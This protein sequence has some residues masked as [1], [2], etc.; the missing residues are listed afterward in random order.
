MFDAWMRTK[1][2]PPLDKIGEVLSRSGLSANQ[3][4]WA[5]FIGGMFVVPALATQ[6]YYLAIAAIA[7][8]R[9]CDGLDGAVARKRGITD[10]GGYLDITLDFIF[11]S[12]VV[13][14]FALAMPEENSLAAAF[15]I[16]SFM[17]TGASFLSFA[18]VA[19]KKNIST[20]IRGKKSIYYLGGLTE[21][22]ETILLFL[23]L[24]LWP[25]KFA[26]MAWVF[27]ALCWLTTSF[28][29]HAALSLFDD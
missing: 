6:S 17:G 7:F 9:L 13:F 4:T 29:I 20:E 11:Y 8:N 26:L 27:G 19:A 1:I 24:C 14:G 21:G 10:L 15:L 5:G 22:T 23:A 28:R 16:F 2:D 3:I 12:A 18:I 25:D